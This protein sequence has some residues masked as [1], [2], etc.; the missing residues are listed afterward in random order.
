MTPENFCYWLQG[1]VELH[2]AMITEE[3][4]QCIKEHLSLVFD[5]QTKTNPGTPQKPTT[6]PWHTPVW[7]GPYYQP[8][9]NKFSD[10][11]PYFTPPKIVC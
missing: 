10:L 3:E 1:R 8:D 5:K 2:P 9:P 4:W 7:T 11:P 6:F